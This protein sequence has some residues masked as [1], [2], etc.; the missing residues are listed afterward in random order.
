M[1]D[2]VL[3]GEMSWRQYAARVE[4]GDAVVLL[5]VGSLEQH[6]HHMSLNV[7]VLL[8]SA[9]S[10]HVARRIGGMVAPALQYGY[11]SQQKSGGGNHYPGT[12]S[13]DGSTVTHTVQD[14]VR[15]LARHGVRQL[16]IMNGHFENSWFV[17]EGVD[18]ALREL[19][20]SG[21][22]DFRIMM[23]SYWDFITDPEVVT[24]LYPDNF[25]GWDLE[26]GGLFETSLMLALYPN[27]VDM[28]EVVAHPPAEFP[29]YDMFPVVPDRTPG[30]GTLSSA[31]NASRDK[32]ELILETCVAGIAA[33][34]RKEFPSASGS[35]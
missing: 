20:Q 34:I 24:K 15:E 27:L 8:P 21:I 33:A 11:K 3:I 7:D 29:P 28:N 5:P 6:G 13:L 19:R 23:L 4:A 16:V 22:D 25:P 9:V 30:P 1:S 14:I 35:A 10:E 17:I 2:T 32:G 12:T 31:E 18:L 26:H